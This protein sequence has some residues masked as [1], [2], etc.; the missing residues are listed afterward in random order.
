MIYKLTC[1]AY[2]NKIQNRLIA[3]VIQCVKSHID[4]TVYEMRVSMVWD[5]FGP[6]LS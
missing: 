1:V 3:L 2:E 6:I 5:G 4:C